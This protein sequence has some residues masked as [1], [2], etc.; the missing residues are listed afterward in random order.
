M[1]KVWVN[2]SNL[3]SGGGKTL[4]LG[5]LKGIQHISDIHFTIYHDSRFALSKIFLKNNITYVPIK[6]LFER[7]LISKKI[8]SKYSKG[9]T[10]IYL[11]N[12]PPLINFKNC[13]TILLLSN[14]FYVDSPKYVEKLN[15]KIRFKIFLEKLYFKLFIKNVNEI[16]VQTQTMKDLCLKSKINL[17]IQILPFDDFN[18]IKPKK[19]KKI[20]NSFLYVASTLPYKNH[21]RLLKAFSILKKFTKKYTLFITLG[22]KSDKISLRIRNEIKKNNLNVILLED[23]SRNK[24]LSYFEKVENLI[25]PSLFEAYGLPLVEAK[26]YNMKIISADLDYAWD[27]IK[28]DDFFNPYSSISIFRALTRVLDVNVPQNEILKPEQFINKLLKK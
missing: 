6:S 19:I 18:N 13:K 16:I 24:L 8:N 28:P 4:M 17:N 1:K 9:D 10:V 26:R 20:K 2:A 27:L 3:H 11:G 7:V 14:R 15:L 22:S 21:L 5:F 25:Y 23:I 12:L